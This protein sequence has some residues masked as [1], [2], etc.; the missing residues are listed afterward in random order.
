VRDIQ[1]SVAASKGKEGDALTNAVHENDAQVAAKIRKQAELG[2][3]AS[4]VRI[5][6]GYYDL[7]T[8]KV[9]WAEK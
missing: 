2:E 1:P 9:E 7:D 5:V 6:E 3:L 4:Q 8:G